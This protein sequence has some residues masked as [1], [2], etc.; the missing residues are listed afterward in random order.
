[1]VVGNIYIGLEQALRQA[2]EAAVPPAEE[3]V[4]LAVHGTLHVTGMDHPDRAELRASSP[5]YLLQERLVEA[6]AR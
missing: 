2:A 5:M 6:L 4:R 3:M 1:M